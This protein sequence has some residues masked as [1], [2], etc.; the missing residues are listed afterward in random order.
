L[1]LHVNWLHKQITVSL[2]SQVSCRIRYWLYRDKRKGLTSLLSSL[3][4][5]ASVHYKKKNINARID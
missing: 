1:Y 4:D 5:I 3:N 2:I